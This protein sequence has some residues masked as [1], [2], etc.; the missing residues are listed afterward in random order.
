[1]KCCLPLHWI[2]NKLQLL[3]VPSDDSGEESAVSSGMQFEAQDTRITQEIASIA[4]STDREVAQIC[5]PKEWPD[6]IMNP[7]Y[8]SGTG[9]SS[10]GNLQESL[11]NDS[12]LPEPSLKEFPIPPM[13]NVDACSRQ[14]SPCS[15]RISDCELPQAV[16]E[17]PGIEPGISR[18]RLL[19]TLGWREM[20]L[21]DTRDLDSDDEA[22]EAFLM[23][24][25]KLFQET[26]ARRNQGATPKIKFVMNL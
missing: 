25:L 15:E 16:H 5:G 14:H 2:V 23:W 8:N 22:D 17:W 19:N 10:D 20:L 13:N 12:L 9:S 6:V 1:M 24:K 11:T 3:E 4:S 26:I 18:I 7:V 21:Y